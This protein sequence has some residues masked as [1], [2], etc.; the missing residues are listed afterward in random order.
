MEKVVG[1][2][3]LDTDAC[4]EI[5]RASSLGEKI[6][7]FLGDSEIA[8]S[9]IS[10]FELYSRETHLEQIDFFLENVNIISF[11]EDAAKI[12]SDLRKKLMKLGQGIEFRD[13]FVG[14]TCISHNYL[15]LTLN[16]KHFERIKD[17]KIAEI[18]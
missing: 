11:D 15:L 2:I 10:V 12:A 1:T 14:A 17:L 13:I 4:I 9:S 16:K 3:C 7:S 6:L 18:K 8:L 5:I